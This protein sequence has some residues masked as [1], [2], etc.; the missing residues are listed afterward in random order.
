LKIKDLEQLNCIEQL[1]LSHNQIGKIEGL[2]EFLYEG[3]WGKVEGQLLRNLDTKFNLSFNQ[4]KKIEGLKVFSKIKDL[5]L[6]L[7]HNQITK[8]EG[9]EN[10]SNLRSLNLNLSYNQISKIE[11]LEELSNLEILNLDFNHNQISKIEGLK[12]LPQLKSLNLNN[13]KIIEIEGLE[14]ASELRILDLSNNKITKLEGLKN[15]SK[16]TDLYLAHNQVNIIEGLEGLLK[17]KILYLEDA[18]YDVGSADDTD[19]LT[20]GCD[21]DSADGIVSEAVAYVEQAFVLVEV[22]DRLCHEVV[23]CPV[24]FVVEGVEQSQDILFGENSNQG[25]VVFDDRDAGDVVVCHQLQGFKDGRLFSYADHSLGH[26]I[27]CLK[28][29]KAPLSPVH[30]ARGDSHARVQSVYP[31]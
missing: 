31:S 12:G 6:D 13:N 28:H 5:T 26:Y 4:I 19:N 15:L 23:D 30:L 10:L 14:N 17:L 21:R 29:H 3:I 16:L 20:V 2:P 1:D 11:G 25:L 9:L 18:L 22:N 27:F 24:F 7:S 8:I